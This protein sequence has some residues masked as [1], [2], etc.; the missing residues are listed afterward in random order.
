MPETNTDFRQMLV[1]QDYLCC[2][3]TFDELHRYPCFG[4]MLERILPVPGVHQFL[5]CLDFEKAAVD[6][7]RRATLTPAHSDPAHSDPVRSADTQ[8]D[9]DL[10]WRPSMGA[11]PALQYFRI[12]PC[13]EDVLPGGGKSPPEPEGDG[14]A[15][16]HWLR[17]HGCS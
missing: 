6:I 3:A 2:P 5:R 17:D 8:I 14:D 4:H 15:L 11:P 1:Y 9:F 12:R 7:H 16:G 13:A 10:R